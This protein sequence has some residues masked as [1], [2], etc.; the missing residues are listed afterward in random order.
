MTT[1][2]VALP[3]SVT[4]AP[5]SRAL[6]NTFLTLLFT[7][8]TL[9]LTGYLWDHAGYEMLIVTMG[10]PHVILGFAFYFGRVLNG[11]KDSR[12]SFLL[13]SGATITLWTIH[14]YYPITGLIYLYFLFHLFRDEIF[15]YMQ[16]RS[17]HQSSA[18]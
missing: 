3:V 17:G 13:L 8:T 15:V 10:W 6:R 7:V 4:S 2:S 1:P 18:S 9:T 14:Y 11:Q 12:I 5:L 16:T